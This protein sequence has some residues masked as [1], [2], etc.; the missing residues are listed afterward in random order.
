MKAGLDALDNALIQRMKRDARVSPASMARE[1]RVSRAT[2]GRRLRRIRNLGLVQIAAVVTPEALGYPVN[3]Y[4]TISTEF[5]ALPRVGEA[6]VALDALRFVAAGSGTFDL[7]AA[8]SFRSDEHL[9][10]F[11]AEDLAAIPG[12]RATETAHV[13]HRAKHLYKTVEPPGIGREPHVP[14]ICLE[15]FDLRLLQELTDDGLRTYSAIAR[16]LGVSEGTVRKRLNRLFR[17][18]ALRIIALAG[19]GSSV[20]RVAVLMQMEAEPDRMFA[21]ADALS[22]RDDTWTVAITAGPYD[23][24]A[25][26]EVSSIN[27]LPQ[28]M[29]DISREIP[30]IRRTRTT[31]LIRTLKRT[32]TSVDL[33]Y[34]HEALSQE[35]H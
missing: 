7:F 28:F 26:V 8:G 29:I 17:A 3:T 21:L 25:F 5:G 23:V 24:A 1:L 19:K 14:E 10:S 16:H 30:G 31:R 15:P 13:V 9:Y 2:V 20:R 11:V 32:Y 27:D 33:V 12:I 18:G 35:Q 6:L 22:E 4:F 34:D